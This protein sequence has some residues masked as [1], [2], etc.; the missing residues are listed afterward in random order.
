MQGAPQELNA[1]LAQLNRLE[2]LERKLDAMQGAPNDIAAR[3]D[4]ISPC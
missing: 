1:R 4:D 2:S 3:L